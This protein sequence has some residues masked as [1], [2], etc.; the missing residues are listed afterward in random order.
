M[1]QDFLASFIGNQNQARILR[2][3]ILNEGERFT[4]KELAK[5]TGMQSDSAQ[6]ALDKLKA[7][8]IVR[9]VT[10]STPAVGKKKEISE[11]AWFLNESFEHLKPLTRF[12]RDISPVQYDEIVDALKR[13][14]KLSAVVLSGS[15]MGDESRPADIL[16]AADSLNEERLETAVK[17]LEPMFGKELR[18][19]VFSTPEFRY[20]LT[21]Q[22][23]LLRD[24]FDFPHVVLLDRSGV[25]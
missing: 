24:T 21:V 14:G 18:Y 25:L 4:V 8:H 16:V 13:T 11:K 7:M 22:D 12:V 19:A 15:F 5:R 9:S 3:I 2:T 1:K 10:V 6:D 20:R 23:K 17:Q